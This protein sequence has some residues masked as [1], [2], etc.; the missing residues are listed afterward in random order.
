MKGVIYARYSSDSQ[1]EESIE[2]QLRECKAFAEKNDITLLATY[3]DRA[4][5]ANTD[6]RPDFQRMVKDSAKGL[7][8]VVIVWKLDRFARNRYDS[9]QYKPP[10]RKTVCAS[11][12]PPSRSRRTP[13]EF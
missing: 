6:N 9:A 13:P 4:L 7:F 5:S 8:D 2:G 11:Y 10:S 12:R 3:V 1:R